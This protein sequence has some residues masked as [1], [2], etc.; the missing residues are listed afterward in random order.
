MCICDGDAFLLSFNDDKKIE[1]KRNQRI[2]IIATRNQLNGDCRDRNNIGCKYIR[3]KRPD[4][5]L[6]FILLHYVQSFTESTILYETNKGNNG[7][8]H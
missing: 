2:I 4:M 1:I 3:V 6:F 8:T 5:D 7:K